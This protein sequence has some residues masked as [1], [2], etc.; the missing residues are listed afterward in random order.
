MC[1]RLGSVFCLLRLVRVWPSQR[2]HSPRRNNPTKQRDFDIPPLQRPPPSIKYNSM[3]D[4]LELTS[5]TAPGKLFDSREALAAHYQTSWHKYNLK[6][7]SAGLPALPEADFEARWA[8]AQAVRNEKK[9]AG[10]NH[11]KN[12]DHRKPNNVKRNHQTNRNQPDEAEEEEDAKED[13]VVF[14]SQVPAYDRI[15]EDT[16]AM[17][18]S[19]VVSDDTGAAN[20]EEQLDQVPATVSSGSVVAG[21]TT[22]TVDAVAVDAAPAAAQPDGM[23]ASGNEENEAED[24][25][26]KEEQIE[27]DPCQSL[28]DRHVSASAQENADYLYQTYGFFIPDREFLTDLEG[29][30]GYCQ[31]KI[32][33]GHVCLYCQKR[34]ATGSACTMHMKS[35]N[36]TK[37]RYEANIDLDEFDVF[38]DFTAVNREFIQSQ[39]KKQSRLLQDAVNDEAE[40]DDDG[41]EDWEDVPENAAEESDEDDNGEEWYDDYQSDMNVMGFDVTALGEIIFPDGRI[42]GHRALRKYYRQNLRPTAPRSVA[43]AAARLAAGERLYRGRVYSTTMVSSTQ[44]PGSI[45]HCGLPPSAG[46][47]ILVASGADGT[48]TQLSVYRYMAAVRKQRLDSRQGQ[49]LM[50]RTTMNM[51]KMDKK[52]NRMM[53]GVSVA[54]AKR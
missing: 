41:D 45:Q 17:V 54:H 35:S 33:I 1:L 23:A 38:Y 42:I 11:L 12:K 36:H 51:N 28:F 40:D 26:E 13:G 32:Q 16:A 50:E 47:G 6:R 39:R 24:E 19:S 9:E 52:H 20:T 37:L 29:L 46:K 25:E 15:K 21:S 43:V 2:H 31:E 8:A 22:T 3:A 14:R 27:I 34:F 10:T 48:Y 18:E 4:I 44:K 53:N 5:T 30:L 49:K 7:R